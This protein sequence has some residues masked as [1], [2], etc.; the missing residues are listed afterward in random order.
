[1]AASLDGCRGGA[2]NADKT[3]RFMDEPE[4]GHGLHL[5]GLPQ[6]TDG[7]GHEASATHKEKDHSRSPLPLL[8]DRASELR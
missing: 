2:G 8:R 6:A 5:A 4:V 1:M 3:A 7:R